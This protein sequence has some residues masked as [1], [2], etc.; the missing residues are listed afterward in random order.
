MALSTRKQNFQKEKKSG[1]KA[2][3][4]HTRITLKSK[5]LPNRTANL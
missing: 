3:E 2:Q 1:E 4:K 5:K